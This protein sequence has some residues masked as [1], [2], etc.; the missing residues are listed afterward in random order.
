MSVNWEPIIAMCSLKNVRTSM[1]LIPAIAGTALLGTE[2]AW[3][4]LEYR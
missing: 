4:S 1:H 3:V 2:L